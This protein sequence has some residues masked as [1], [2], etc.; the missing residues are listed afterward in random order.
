L[1]KYDDDKKSKLYDVL[2]S[3]LDKMIEKTYDLKRKSILISIKEVVEELKEEASTSDTIDN[4]LNDS[5]SEPKS[6]NNVEQSKTEE[7]GVT[8]QN[9]VKT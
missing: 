2:L 5:N 9:K 6:E 3:K 4:I 7:K 1:S 8:D